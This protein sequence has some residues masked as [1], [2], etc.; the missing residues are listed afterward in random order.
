ML[1]RDPTDQ[2]V[3]MFDSLTLISCPI[4]LD[5]LDQLDP[6]FPTNRGFEL[7]SCEM[8]GYPNSWM[9]YN[10]KIPLKWMMTRGT[11]ISGNRYIDGATCYGTAKTSRFTV[12]P[13]I[14]LGLNSYR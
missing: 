5:T 12:S 4:I 10:G 7:C 8:W 6:S 9:A 14:K 3:R 1:M 11:P 2:H 13:G